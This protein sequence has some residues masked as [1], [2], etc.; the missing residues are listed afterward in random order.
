LASG[1]KQVRQLL[2]YT[3]ASEREAINLY[4]I[5]GSNPPKLKLY[6]TTALQTLT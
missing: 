4:L 6:S 1:P 3:T 5:N 2:K